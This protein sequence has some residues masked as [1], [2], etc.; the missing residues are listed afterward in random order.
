M[1][2]FCMDFGVSK[3]WEEH[4]NRNFDGN[5]RLRLGVLRL[6]ENGVIFDDGNRQI[7]VDCTGRLNNPPNCKRSFQGISDDKVNF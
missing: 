2:A 7:S 6:P 1:S 3:H 4:K 5:Y